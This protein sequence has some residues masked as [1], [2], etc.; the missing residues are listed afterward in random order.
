MDIREYTIEE[1]QKEIDRKKRIKER[2]KLINEPDLS[3]L[4]H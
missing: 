2:P 4:K 3:Q 1:L